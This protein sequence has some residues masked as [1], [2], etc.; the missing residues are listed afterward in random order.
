[1]KN[2]ILITLTTLIALST[3]T[4]AQGPT[5]NME[6][7]LL[8]ADPY[9]VQ[10]GDDAEVSFKIQNRGNTEAENVEVEIM[11]TFPF[12]LKPDRK[13]T[14][15]V[16]TVAPGESYY[17]TSEVLVSEDAPDGNNSFEVR[18]TNGDF[19]KVEKI[20]L[21]VQSD[22]INLNLANLKTSPNELVADTQDNTLSVDVVNNGEKTA[23]NVVL[24]LDTPTFFE[25]QSS[26]STR[27]ALGNIGPGEVKTGEFSFDISENASKGQIE[28]PG[29]ISYTSS[30]S[31]AEITEDTSF[32]AFISGRPSYEITSVSS[33][34]KQGSQGTITVG[35]E[36]TG[37][38]KSSSTRVR[39]LE[40][41]DLPFSFSSSNKFV[42]SLEPGDSGT[43]VFDASVES[44]A[45]PKDYL[46]DFEIRGVKDTEVFVSEKVETVE[47]TSSESSGGSMLVPIAALIILVGATGIYVFREKI[48]PRE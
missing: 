20:P 22:Q 37:S 28:V 18:I 38:E 2:K 47:V 7:V 39:V 14:Y 48:F 5:T 16:G 1:M 43:V 13:R 15:N 24:E 35:V 3:L 26:F 31:S 30:D 40:N 33:D 29:T 34:L 11:D 17:I 8:T 32:K 42:G 12:E 41:S 44:D 6:G 27:Q 23:E 36:N 21:S 19:S 9:P 4:T 45:T 25:S 10:S 46:M